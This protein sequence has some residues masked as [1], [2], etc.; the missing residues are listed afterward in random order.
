M[1][2]SQLRAP[3]IIGFDGTSLGKELCRHLQEVNPAGL[4]LFQRNI[5]SIEQTKQLLREL[6]DLLGD[7]IFAI[8]HEGGI[9]NR[10]PENTPV[11]PSP[12][13]LKASG[14][15]SN[16]RAACTIQAE[17]L[18]Y[19]GFNMN[20][21]PLIDL[22]LYEENRVIGTRAY[23]DNPGEVAEYAKICIE[24]HTALKIGTTAKHFP[25]HGRTITDTHFAVGRVYHQN[26]A[27]LD[28]DLD[29]YKSAIGCGVPAIMTAHLIYPFL[30][31][32]HPASLSRPILDELLR[33]RMGFEGLIISDCVEME[34]LA[35]NY[36]PAAIIRLGIRAG[37]DLFISSFSLKKSYDFQ[38][39][40]NQAFRN[41]A[42]EAPLLV[43]ESNNR[44][45]LFFNRFPRGGVRFD[46][47][48]DMASTIALHKAT[49]EKQSFAPLLPE[50][51]SFVLVE[52]TNREQQGINLGNEWNSAVKVMLTHCK[53]MVG[54]ELFYSCD[55]LKLKAMIDFCNQN[56]HT[57]VLL[58]ANG[59][60][61]QGY[62]AF[63][64]LLKSAESAIHIALVDPAD[65]K[66]VCKNEWATRGFNANS[67]K[68]LAEELNNMV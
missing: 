61:K 64:E 57:C 66:R 38:L 37:V 6:A 35:R 59:H 23:S 53:N 2:N 4:I 25:T 60:R 56:L 12:A 48:P 9:V 7:T 49:L 43:N 24:A 27:E 21:V 33:K 11:P 68:M 63:I 39:A 41:V 8:D 62:P 30:D 34:G 50:Y 3:F 28:L 18:A 44:R 17:L 40:L 10:F 67:G 5:Q 46:K 16:V 54:T 47:F 22:A 55:D 1:K 36:D 20:F 42:T 58:T 26:Q 65:L 52:L 14:S 31:T 51:R 29:P 13:A 19:L 32:E 45:R 15:V